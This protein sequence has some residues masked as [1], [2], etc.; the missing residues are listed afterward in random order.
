MN[1]LIFTLN[2]LFAAV[3]AFSYLGVMSEIDPDVVHKVG[4]GIVAIDVFGLEP[5]NTPKGF[6]QRVWKQLQD[7]HQESSA[8]TGFLYEFD[9]KKYIITNRHV[10]DG[11]K[12]GSIH[13][14][15]NRKKY[16]LEELGGDTFYDLAVL[17]FGDR[18]VPALLEPLSFA[19]TAPALLQTA[20]IV[21]KPP[22]TLD[23]YAREGQ[24][25]SLI[26]QRMGISGHFDYIETS[27]KIK[28]G[29]SGSPLI[30]TRG[31]VI[32]INT[33]KKGN[34]SYALAGAL[35]EQLI[36]SMIQ[37]D[38][39]RVKRA[40]L[41]LEFLQTIDVGEGGS[42]IPS[43]KTPR[44]KIQGIIPA[45]PASQHQEQ[46]IG[47]S[48]RSL[49]GVSV[50]SLQ[51]L[52]LQMEYLS[53]GEEVVLELEKARNMGFR[54]LRLIAGELTEQHL[55][56]I[57]DYFLSERTPL[58]LQHKGG[59]LQLSG[60]FADPRLDLVI[61]HEAGA[62]LQVVASGLA[63]SFG[64]RRLFQIRS[65]QELGIMIRLC[66]LQGQLNLMGVLPSDYQELLE[67]EEE[68]PIQ[69]LKI[70]FHSDG[71]PRIGE[72]TSALYY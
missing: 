37:D 50:Y 39:G 33:W 44:P 35:A 65:K 25:N 67:G 14:I 2:I 58:S 64:G 72:F 28:A 17:T 48:V 34:K 29:C 22:P 57:A 68:I 51:D 18:P 70:R 16:V 60:N 6:M 43:D 63:E 19:P 12:A 30:N 10:V 1:R 66:S 20:G 15:V 62:P 46:Y 69:T 8:G 3:W 31:E 59:G 27:A 11:A 53:P 45:G 38:N 55:V 26:N 40:Y 42:R 7:E 71:E 47:Y 54:S 56:E 13:A 49:N 41:G 24:I 4:R 21:A 5:Y 23:L 61:D 32:G 52:L 9:N 36:Q